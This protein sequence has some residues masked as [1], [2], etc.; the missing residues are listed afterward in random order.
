MRKL[1]LSLGAAA[2]VALAGAIIAP[3]LLAE[4]PDRATALMFAG[5][6][7]TIAIAAVIGE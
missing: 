5:G 4:P 1:I 7:F 3:R 6:L 2:S